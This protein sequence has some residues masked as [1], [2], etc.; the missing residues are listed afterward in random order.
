MSFQTTVV[1]LGKRRWSSLKK[2]R[3][4]HKNNSPSELK[5]QRSSS[6]SPSTVNESEHIKKNFLFSGGLRVD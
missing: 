2:K 1:K 5:G 4:K 6:K 3:L